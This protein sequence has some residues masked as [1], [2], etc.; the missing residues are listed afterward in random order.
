MIDFKITEEQE[1]LVESLQEWLDNCGF[2]DEY[3]RQHYDTCTY[4]KEYLKALYEGPFGTLG[5]PEDMGGT[6]V[7]TLTLALLNIEM[8]KRDRPSMTPQMVNIDSIAAYGTKEHFER[9]IAS[10]N[11]GYMPSCLAI[12]EPQAGSDNSGVS[13]TYTRKNGKVYINGHK[14]MITNA[15]C[16]NQ[17]QVLCRDFSVEPYYKA[18]TMWMVPQ[19]APGITMETMHKIGCKLF[20]MEEI[21]FE[22]VEIEEKELF[23]VEHKGFQQLMKNFETERV[24]ICAVQLG[25]ATAAYNE[26]ATYAA[27]R[28]QFGKKIDEFQLIQ[29][30]LSLSAL[31][32]ENMRNLI[33]KVAWMIDNKMSIRAESAMCKL[34]C[35][36]SSNEICD[37][38]VQIFGGYGYTEDCKVSKFWRD[39]RVSR[40]GG[41]TDEIMIRSIAKAIPK[42]Y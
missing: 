15:K 39:A 38:A 30:K 23:G 22:N 17:I 42:S 29:E 5:L 37:D 36:R 9:A 8:A 33:Y 27:Q 12:T 26:A 24:L 1:L 21:Y 28:E 32:L 20:T 25:L 7:D 10:M 6:P 18:M 40:I 35:A 16:T 2:D 41:G 31:K 19:D 14:T 4:P 3:F 13:T 11:E 34:Y